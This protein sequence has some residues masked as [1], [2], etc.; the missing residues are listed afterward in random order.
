MEHLLV[1]ILLLTGWISLSRNEI[2][3]N[4][5]AYI[6][7]FHPQRWHLE[8]QLF[9]LLYLDLN[10]REI[11]VLSGQLSV[12]CVQCTLGW[13]HPKT[14]LANP[15]RNLPLYSPWLHP[16]GE[17]VVHRLWG[18]SCSQEKKQGNRACPQN[19]L[20]YYN[21]ALAWEQSEFL[22]L[23][24]KTSLASCALSQAIASRVAGWEV[25]ST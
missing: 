3:I 11:S 18:T 16:A 17:V 6:D 23:R 8:Q 24:T 19:P 21:K 4:S 14:L 22:V 2:F 1:P 9:F 20:L 13:L 25:C 10:T 15:S 5:N 12:Q 7:F